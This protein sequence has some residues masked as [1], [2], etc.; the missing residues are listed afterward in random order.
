[1]GISKKASFI[2][3]IVS[4]FIELV[5]T[6][7]VILLEYLSNT[8]MGVMRSLVYRNEVLSQTY[9]NQGSIYA[10]RI[11]LT[12]GILIFAILLTYRILKKNLRLLFNIIWI[13][14][15]NIA[16]FVFIV[17]KSLQSLN[18]YYYFLIVI[19]AALL[20]EYIKLFA[21]RPRDS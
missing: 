20:I 4:A 3:D 5:L 6:A 15:L 12:A 9:F 10:C 7:A 8:K 2:A 17:S 11:V 19:F 14:I 21:H 13:L 18:S 16:G 1:M